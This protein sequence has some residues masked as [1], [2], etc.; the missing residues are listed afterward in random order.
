MRIGE[1]EAGKLTY[2]FFIFWRDVEEEEEEED[3]W[4]S[5]E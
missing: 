4:E 2:R 5:I 3:D 1:H